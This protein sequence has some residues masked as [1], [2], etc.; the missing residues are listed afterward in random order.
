M[1]CMH[2]AGV[3]CVEC[4]RADWSK[5]TSPWPFGTQYVSDKFEQLWQ[6]IYSLNKRIYDL[7]NK[8]KE[9]RRK[10]EG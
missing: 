2:I 6:E 8:W 10:G 5:P 1:A 3:T 9:E 7:E 4:S